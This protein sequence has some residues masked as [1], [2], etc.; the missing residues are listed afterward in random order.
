MLILHVPESVCTFLVHHE[1]G[2]HAQGLGFRVRLKVKELPKRPVSAV[3]ACT[4]D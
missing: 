4:V 3:E 1:V 2:T